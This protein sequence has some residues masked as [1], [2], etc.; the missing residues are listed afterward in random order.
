MAGTP[1]W[2][3]LTDELARRVAPL[4]GAEPEEVTIANSTTVSLHQL[5]STLYRPEGRRNRILIDAHCFP[6]DRYAIRS[7]LALRGMDPERH[8]IVAAARE[9]RLLSES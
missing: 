8:L 2:F 7:H 6:S 1:P 3:T 5:L 4:L 9:D